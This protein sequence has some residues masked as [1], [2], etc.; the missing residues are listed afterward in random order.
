M[1]LKSNISSRSELTTEELENIEKI[2]AIDKP[3]KEQETINLTLRCKDKGKIDDFAKVISPSCEPT[4]VAAPSLGRRCRLFLQGGQQ[5]GKTLFGSGR[6]ISKKLSC[7]FT[8]ARSNRYLVGNNNNIC[9]HHL[10]DGTSTCLTHSTHHRERARRSRL[11]EDALFYE[12]TFEAPHLHGHV[13]EE[14]PKNFLQLL[15]RKSKSKRR[16]KRPSSLSQS[17][18]LE[19]CICLKYLNRQKVNTGLNAQNRTHRRYLDEKEN[20][21]VETP[22]NNTT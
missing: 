21:L 2:E 22:N 5:R 14:S 8:G 1:A 6:R 11:A 10:T 20:E 3:F 18:I 16:T 12:D 13:K 9:Q 19:N 7:S 17:P 15:H 4:K